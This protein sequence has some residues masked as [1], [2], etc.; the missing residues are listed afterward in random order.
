M[1]SATP[2]DRGR[3]APAKNPCNTDGTNACT[4]SKVCFVSGGASGLGRATAV[5]LARQQYR[6]AVADRDETAG[7][8]VVEEI[9]AL[10][11]KRR[12]FRSM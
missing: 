2:A 4:K 10:A 11:A 6:I 5:A 7:R 3:H 12:S 1:S 8:R 9:S